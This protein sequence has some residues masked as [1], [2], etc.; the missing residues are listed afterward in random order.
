MGRKHKEDE[1]LRQ[2]RAGDLVIRIYR[3]SGYDDV[4]VSRYSSVVTELEEELV[5]TVRV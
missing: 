1:E 4:E 5:K 3:G 2:P